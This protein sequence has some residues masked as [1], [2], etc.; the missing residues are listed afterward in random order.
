MNSNAIRK[1]TVLA[2]TGVGLLVASQIM[3]SKKRAVYWGI[4][5]QLDQVNAAVEVGEGLRYV[6]VRMKETSVANSPVAE[7]WRMKQRKILGL[8]KETGRP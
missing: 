8:V 7:G 3:P 6:V 4:T 1:T 5:D 2:L